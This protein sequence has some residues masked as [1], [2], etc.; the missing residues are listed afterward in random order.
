[1]IFKEKRE[2][3]EILMWER[4]MNWLLV[5][6]PWLGIKSRTWVSWPTIKPY[7]LWCTGWCCNQLSHTSQGQKYFKRNNGQTFFFYFDKFNKIYKSRNLVKY[8]DLHIQEVHE[9]PQ[10][11]KS[12]LQFIMFFII[13]E[14]VRSKPS[15][16][17]PSLFPLFSIFYISWGFGWQKIMLLWKK[18]LNTTN[19]I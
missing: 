6:V 2:E 14:W 5:H 7:H 1:M 13:H 8:K 12:N 3:R 19:T 10:T 18:R 4:N 15:S 16:V 11:L 17:F 9:T